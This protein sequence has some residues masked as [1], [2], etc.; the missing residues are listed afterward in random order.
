M[1][2]FKKKVMKTSLIQTII[3]LIISLRHYNKQQCP[4]CS[5]DNIR[6]LNGNKSEVFKNVSDK[7]DMIISHF[8]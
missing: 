7:Q 5:N 1:H 8:L 6:D 3:E 4:F 2:T